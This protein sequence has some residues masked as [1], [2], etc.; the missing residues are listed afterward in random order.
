MKLPHIHRWATH[1]RA[2]STKFPC[3]TSTAAAPPAAAKGA[4][5]EKKPVDEAKKAAIAKKAKE[6]APAIIKPEPLADRF[7]LIKIA[8]NDEK[9][10]VGFASPAN[11]PKKEKYYVTTAI[12]YT[13]GNPHVGHAYEVVLADYAARFNRMYGRDTFFLSGTDEHGQKIA[14]T[15][16]KLKMTPQAMVDMYCER[17]QVLYQR[18]RVSEDHFVRT[19]HEQHM[20]TA[21][22]LWKMCEKVKDD[23]Y[24]ANYEGWSKI[25]FTF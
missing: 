4:K 3:G 8:R 1:V 24:L 25:F 16:E 15:A 2:L 12:M 22:K 20:D 9:F 14:E 13:N 23:I 7:K 18:L 6:K 21:R 10:G 19:T 5:A 17:F 11:A